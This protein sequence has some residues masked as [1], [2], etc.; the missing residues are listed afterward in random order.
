MTEDYVL[1]PVESL[2]NHG[3]YLIINLGDNALS[4]KVQFEDEF[5]DV[6]DIKFLAK[7][8]QSGQEIYVKLFDE[9]NGVHPTMPIR[10]EIERIFM[11]RK[12]FSLLPNFILN[13]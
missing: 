6:N 11:S 8:L 2:E 5:S 9:E 1:L 13:N 4:V 12:R 10:I 7:E 3:D